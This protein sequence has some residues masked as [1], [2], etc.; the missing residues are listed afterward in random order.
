MCYEPGRVDGN[1]SLDVAIDLVGIH[2]RGVLKVSREAMV[3]ADEGIEDLSEINIGI[4]ITS[5]HTTMLVVEL[6]SAGN[7]LGQSELRGLG[8]NAGEFIP[9]FLG[10]VGSDQRVLGLDI[11]EGGHGSEKLGFKLVYQLEFE[12]KTCPDVRTKLSIVVRQ[13]FNH[14]RQVTS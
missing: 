7:G 12:F 4:L 5:I 9:P 11:R 6:N 14:C 10:H 3:L 1:I 2:V 8:H 13:C